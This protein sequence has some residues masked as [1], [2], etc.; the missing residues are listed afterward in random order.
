MANARCIVL[1]GSHI[2]ENLH[3]GQVQT[4]TA[5]INRDATL[6]TVDRRFSVPAGKSKHWLPIKP[7]TDI[8]LLLAW[9]NVLIEEDLY[10]KEY[11]DRYTLG[12]EQLADHVRQYTPEWVS[13]KPASAPK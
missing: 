12:F 10:D 8:A 5:A 3:N 9:M 7:G 1:L 13:P 2:G 6:I 4:L 11:V